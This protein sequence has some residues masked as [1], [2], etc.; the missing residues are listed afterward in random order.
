L[1]FFKESKLALG[2]TQPSFSVLKAVIMGVK[3]LMC[4]GDHSPPSRV[5]VKVRG[6][7]TLLSHMLLQ[8]A[9]GYIYLYIM[10]GMMLVSVFHRGNPFKSRTY[11]TS[12]L[13]GHSLHYS[14]TL[15]L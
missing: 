13:F 5:E 2:P 12:S 15:M 1:V 11:T 6:Y 3:W 14:S 9:D 7:V 10:F 4:E 8:C